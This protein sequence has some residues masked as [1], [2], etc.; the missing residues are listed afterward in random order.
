MSGDAR[1][2][3]AVGEKA[4]KMLKDVSEVLE[5]HGVEYILDCGT[6]LGIVR[7]NRLLPW[8]NDVDLAVDSSQIPKLKKCMLALWLKGYRVR[9]ARTTKESS[10]ISINAPRILRVRNR[11]RLIHRGEN[12]IDI[13]IKYD[14][15]DGYHYLKVGENSRN[16]IEQKFPSKFLFE[17]SSIDFNGKAY[18]VPKDYAEYLT[19]RYGDWKVPVKDWDFVSQ[20][21][22]RHL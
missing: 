4:L 15:G 12:L 3:G 16:S 21:L 10:I 8:D 9:F 14:G 1:L 7:E 11:K 2:E 19:Y 5:R 18:P 17:R 20:D 6:L 13:F 22:S